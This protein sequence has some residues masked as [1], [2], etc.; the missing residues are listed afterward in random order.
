MGELYVPEQDDFIDK[1][2]GDDESDDEPGRNQSGI[3]DC[4]DDVSVLQ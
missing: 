4:G 1:F 2:E 3:G